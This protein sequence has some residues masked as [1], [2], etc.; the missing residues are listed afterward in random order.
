MLQPLNC[1][2][3]GYE[4]QKA[5]FMGYDR[6]WTIIDKYASKSLRTHEDTECRPLKDAQQIA[7]TIVLLGHAVP[8]PAVIQR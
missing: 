2:K 4:I 3:A 1:S 8:L 7:T 6:I 5:S